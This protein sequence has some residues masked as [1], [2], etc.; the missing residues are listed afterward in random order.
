M[1]REGRFR[2]DLYYRLNVIP[3]RVPPLRERRDDI[4]LLVD[5]FVKTIRLRSEKEIKGVTEEAMEQLMVYA[6]PGNVRELVNALEYAFVVCH[7]G[8]ISTQHLPILAGRESPRPTHFRAGS[9]ADDGQRERLIQVMEQTGGNRQKAAE[10]LGM[11]RVTLW[12]L[13]KKHGIR[14]E[15]KFASP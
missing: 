15:V 7:D 5:H 4:P 9:I 6:W 14:Y 8:L 1:C 2:E 11:S 12:K 3:I 10:I 13:L